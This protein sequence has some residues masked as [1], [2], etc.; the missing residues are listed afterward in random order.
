[1]DMQNIDQG[2]HQLKKRNLLWPGVLIVVG[3]V[4][5]L[6]NLGFLSP[7]SLGKLWPLLLVIWGADLIWRRYHESM[8]R[9]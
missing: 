7:V 8:H 1:M 9:K 5:L 2:Y 6:E 3:L 4:F